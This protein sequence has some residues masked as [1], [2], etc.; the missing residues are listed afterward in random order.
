MEISSPEGELLSEIIVSGGGAT[1]VVEAA[2]GELLRS[3]EEMR[4]YLERNFSKK[5]S[6]YLKKRC[7]RVVDRCHKM[8]REYGK[9]LKI[10]ERLDRVEN[11]LQRLVE[12]EEKNRLEKVVTR[13]IDNMGEQVMNM[14]RE[15]FKR[16]SEGISLGEEVVRM[17]R[18]C[19]NVGEKVEKVGEEVVKVERVWMKGTDP[20]LSHDRMVS[21]PILSWDRGTVGAC[22]GPVTIHG[23]WDLSETTANGTGLEESAGKEDPVELDSSL[24]L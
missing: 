15:E 21:P 7:D 11:K 17:E 9:L 13:R 10:T 19:E 16:M 24:V 1:N 22:P 20:S 5:H 8:E 6:K 14:V 2:G 12:D 23:L 18:V 4:V 3:L